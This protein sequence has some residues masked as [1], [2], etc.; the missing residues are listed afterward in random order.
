M[1]D[2]LINFLY[3]LPGRPGLQQCLAF[4]RYQGEIDVAAYGDTMTID[5]VMEDE[6]YA[7]H[8]MAA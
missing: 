6:L 7:A 5:W 2:T 4:T 3:V 8:F 1:P